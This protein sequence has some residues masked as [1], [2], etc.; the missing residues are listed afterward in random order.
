MPELQ[1]SSYA[2]KTCR[3]MIT[4]LTG[5]KCTGIP[6][7]S[8][9]VIQTEG[10]LGGRYVSLS[11]RGNDSLLKDGNEIEPQPALEDLINKLFASF[12]SS[13]KSDSEETK[14]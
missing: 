5:N 4:R 2:P 12:T 9:G 3:A 11:P 14:K 6:D 13:G 7:G 8:A 10:L 1:K